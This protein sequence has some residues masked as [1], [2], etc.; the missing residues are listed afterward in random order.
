MTLQCAKKSGCRTCFGFTL[1]ELLLAMSLFAVL[2]GILWNLMSLFS[3]SQNQGIF[4]AEQSQLVR[5]LAQLLEDDLRAAIQDPIHPNLK[6]ARGDDDVRRFG[7]SGNATN[8]RLD[9]LEINPFV[10]V[11]TTEPE[12]AFFGESPSFRPNAAELKTVFYEFDFQTGLKRREINFE[13]LDLNAPGPVGSF[14]QASEIV[15]FC[16]RYFDGTNWKNSWDSLSEEGLP[17]AIEATLHSLPLSESTKFRSRN[18]LPDMMV[19]QHAVQLGLRVPAIRRIVAF[20]PTS[21]KRSF[22][23][24]KRSSPETKPTLSAFDIPAPVIPQFD[25]LPP[26][27]TSVE[28]DVSNPTWIRGQ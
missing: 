3:R 18:M 11:R 24:Y 22:T 27:N 25:N 10:P 9:V 19:E 23:S 8:L 12:S 17:I 16:F 21:A 6:Q 14:M 5:S 20:L 13:T 26:P 4:L 15:T 2:M 1:M 28:A 7:L